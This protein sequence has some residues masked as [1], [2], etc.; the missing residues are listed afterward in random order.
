MAIVRLAWTALFKQKRKMWWFWSTLSF[1]P[2]PFLCSERFYHCQYYCSFFLF[3]KKNPIHSTL[4]AN[5]YV[6]IFTDSF[7][8]YFNGTLRS[9]WSLYMYIVSIIKMIVPKW[10]W[11]VISVLILDLFIFKI[12]RKNENGIEFHRLYFCFIFPI[13]IKW[14]FGCNYTSTFKP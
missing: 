13:Q 10:K 11:S 2:E 12:N 3:R 9:H 6:Y 8:I 14:N 1:L 7:K 5:K 4:M